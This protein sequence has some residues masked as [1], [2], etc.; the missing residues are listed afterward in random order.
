MITL[1][2]LLVKL[3]EFMVKIVDVSVLLLISNLRDLMS[4]ND[5]KYNKH[6]VEAGNCA[7]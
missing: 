6:L 5:D 7:S 1:I 2:A 4:E 3:I